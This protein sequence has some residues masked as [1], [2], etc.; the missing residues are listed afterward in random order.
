MGTVW[1]GGL[2]GVAVLLL[3]YLAHKTRRVHQQGFEVLEQLRAIRLESDH[4]FSQLQSL[5]QLER[6]LA[7]PQGLPPL[8]GWAGSPD[9]L[10]QLARHALSAR[11][12]VVVECSCGASTVVLARC[13]Q[14]NGAGHVYSLEHDA[15]YADQT[16]RLLD[17]R[18]LGDWAT[19]LHAPLLPDPAWP[20]PWY[21][22]AVFPA[23][24]QSIDLL[25][26]DGPPN[27]VGPL[28][29][30]PALSALASRLG[31][32][33]HLFLDD[34]DRPQEREVVERWQQE[35]PGLSLQ[36]PRAEKGLAVLSR[37]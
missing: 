27:A 9:F 12:E 29:R 13:L 21:D 8:R 16:R 6:L 22:R 33:F 25:V 26:V 11:P 18:G 2:A 10:L 30:Y 7:L 19:V 5:G 34:A 1:A 20:S 36:R 37:A 15:F 35:L 28:A 4:L 17:E 14:M 23:Q 31:E 24:M 32:R 3:V